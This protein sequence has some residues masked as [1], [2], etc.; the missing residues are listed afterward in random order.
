[1]RAECADQA[2][3]DREPGAA[4]LTGNEA[5]PE[6]EDTANPEKLAGDKDQEQREERQSEEI[7]VRDQECAKGKDQQQNDR[8]P[9]NDDA[10][11]H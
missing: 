3:D 7:G 11:V 4:G 8:A 1:V 2:R 5:L 9:T 10:P 6:V